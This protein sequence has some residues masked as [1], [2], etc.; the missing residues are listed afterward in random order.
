MRTE[1]YVIDYTRKL[2]N[3]KRAK[4]IIDAGILLVVSEGFCSV[5]FLRT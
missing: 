5:H 1:D 2:R 3:I 4:R